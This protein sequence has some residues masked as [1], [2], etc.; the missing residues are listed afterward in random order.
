VRRELRESRAVALRPVLTRGALAAGS[1]LV[2]VVCGC[3]GS[4]HKA[5]PTTTIRP[6]V[7]TPPQSVSTRPPTTTTTTILAPGPPLGSLMLTDA[8]SGYGRKP[9]SLAST[10]PTDFEKAVR[11]DAL[12][13]EEDA[14]EALRSGGFLRG[15][16]R[17]WSTE[18]AVSQNFLYVYQFA[19][20][21][22]ARS[23]LDHWQSVAIAGSTRAAPVPFTPS[24]PGA[25]GLKAN[26]PRGSSAVVLIS[27][28]VYAV[29]A[30]ATTGPGRDQGEAASALAFAQYALLP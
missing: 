26:D 13:A 7:S 27:K 11:D 28:G 23:Y 3:S 4:D 24:V 16:Q 20:P 1:A 29:Q 17:Q 19:T 12:S 21:E 9:N 22:G 6:P 14:R 5:E 15:F 10:G 8:P 30:V 2:L 18:P 25:I